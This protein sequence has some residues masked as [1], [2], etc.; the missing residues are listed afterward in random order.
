MLL[1]LNPGQLAMMFFLCFFSTAINACVVQCL[2]KALKIKTNLWDM[3]WLNHA[4]M[5]LNYAPMKFGTLFR[6]NYLKNHYGLKYTHFA[7]FF[8]YLTFLMVATAAAV[9]L[10]ALVTVYSL[11]SYESKIL[12]MTFLITVLISLV[13]LFAPLPIP[14]GRGRLMTMVHNFLVGRAGIARQKKALFVSTVFLV[15]N[16]LLTALRFGI[17]YHSMGKSIH[18]AGYLILGAL[19][20]VVLFIGLTPGSLG[21]REFVLGLGA[22]V[23]GVPLEIGILAAMIDR[24]VLISYT[25]P[26]GGGCLL[27]LW[28]KS[29][30]DLKKSEILELSADNKV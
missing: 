1:R 11:A 17:I 27:Y 25:F 13:F 14:T 24:M 5:L 26:V 18:P 9:G 19:G 21:I 28:H 20:F 2:I 22:V 16:F 15:A 4:A 10:V 29:P 12:A 7:T 23:L 8:I 6:A 3:V 30:S